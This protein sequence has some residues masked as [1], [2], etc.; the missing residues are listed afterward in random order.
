MTR[1][2]SCLRQARTLVD[3]PDASNPAATLDNNLGVNDLA[4]LS[5]LLKQ[6]EG[7]GINIYTHGEMPIRIL[8]P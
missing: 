1:R 4:D 8:A 2:S 7:Q 3:N 6:T 5:A